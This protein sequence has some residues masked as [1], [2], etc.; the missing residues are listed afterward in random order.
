M[1][2]LAVR[3]IRRDIPICPCHGTKHTEGMQQ[4]SRHGRTL[5]YRCR[6]RGC[7][8]KTKVVLVIV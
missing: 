4:Y 5:Y 7:E 3:Y 2:K 6:Q 8:F 1:I